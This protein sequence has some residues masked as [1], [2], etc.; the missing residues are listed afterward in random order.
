MEHRG[1]VYQT[2]CNHGGPGAARA[3]VEKSTPGFAPRCSIEVHVCRF[4]SERA[5]PAQ[6]RSARAGHGR[7]QGT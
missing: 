3:I 2:I 6:R 5:R 1:H 7:A 4:L